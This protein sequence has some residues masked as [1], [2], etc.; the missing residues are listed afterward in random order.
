M[1]GPIRHSWQEKR[2]RGGWELAIQE[3]T[4]RKCSQNFGQGT[5]VSQARQNGFG[6]AHGNPGKMSVFLVPFTPPS[7]LYDRW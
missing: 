5:D 2:D 6:V 7:T 4:T 1:R 3:N